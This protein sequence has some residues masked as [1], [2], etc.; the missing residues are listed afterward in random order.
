MGGL[1]QLQQRLC[2]LVRAL[3][4]SELLPRHGEQGDLVL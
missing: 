1:L 3:L 2:R 4:L